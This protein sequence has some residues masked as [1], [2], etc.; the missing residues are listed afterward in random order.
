MVENASGITEDERIFTVR[1]R[2]IEND[3]TLSDY[4]DIGYILQGDS[5]WTESLWGDERLFFTHTHVSDDLRNI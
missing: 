1:G 4:E 5:E 3:G 2:A